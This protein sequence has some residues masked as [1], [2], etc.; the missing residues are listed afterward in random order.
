[1]Q[2]KWALYCNR[3]LTAYVG[4]KH[5]SWPIVCSYLVT[6]LPAVRRWK[7]GC[8]LL[9][10]CVICSDF[11]QY[12]VLLVSSVMDQCADVPSAELVSV[13]ESDSC[14]IMSFER[15]HGHAILPHS[16]CRHFAGRLTS[17]SSFVVITDAYAVFPLAHELVTTNFS[18]SPIP[19]SFRSIMPAHARSRVSNFSAKQ[20]AISSAGFVFML[21]SH[22]AEGQDH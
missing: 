1:M 22:A 21:I 4:V 5:I 18:V 2:N 12:R 6:W 10:F 17:S 8:L 9:V 20:C 13:T 15:L 14:E 7:I 3:L 19:H 16:P 11:V